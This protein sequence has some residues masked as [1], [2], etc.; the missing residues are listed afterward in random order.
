MYVYSSKHHEQRFLS[1]VEYCNQY[2]GK[3]TMLSFVIH[4]RWRVATLNS[5]LTEEMHMWIIKKASRGIISTDVDSYIKQRTLSS[6]AEIR[7][8]N[9]RESLLSAIKFHLFCVHSPSETL[10]AWE[11]QLYD[12]CK[13]NQRGKH[14]THDSNLLV[15][16]LMLSVLFCWSCK[17]KVDKGTGQ[18]YPILCYTYTQIHTSYTCLIK[19][20]SDGA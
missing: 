16:K 7:S 9:V 1:T 3:S 17:N 15:S 8:A 11:T 18:L 4:V 2:C 14:T 20:L 19:L 12:N 5:K 6:N 10:M 13:Q